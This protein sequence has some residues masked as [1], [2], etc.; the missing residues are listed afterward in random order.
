[1]HVFLVFC[2]ICIYFMDFCFA[3]MTFKVFCSACLQFLEFYFEFMALI[4]SCFVSMPFLG[5]V[6]SYT[7]P[8]RYSFYAW[9]S[10][11]SVSFV[12]HTKRFILWCLCSVHLLPSINNISALLFSF[13]FFFLRNSWLASSPFLFRMHA[14]CYVLFCVHALPCVSL[15]MH[16]L[17]ALVAFIPVLPTILNCWQACA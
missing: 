8:Y 9:I 1:M 15:C 4:A 7:C 17:P 6:A 12:W 5:H 14:L 3:C 13:V 16:I 11:R 2:L 10:K